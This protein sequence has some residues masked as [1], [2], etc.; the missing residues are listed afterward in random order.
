MKK[1]VSLLLALTMVATALVGCG[2]NGNVF[3]L[4]IDNK[5]FGFKFT[6]LNS[7]LDDIVIVKNYLPHYEYIVKKNETV[8]DIL[9]R[10]FKMENSEMINEGD[11]IVIHK[12][13]SIRYITKP[14]EKIE[15]IA[16]KSQPLFKRLLESIKNLFKRK[17]K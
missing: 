14:L 9:S 10:G 8:M 1:L 12:P 2:A 17:E 11:I 13:K 16:N 15:D 6:E 5:K 3:K 4:I 7:G